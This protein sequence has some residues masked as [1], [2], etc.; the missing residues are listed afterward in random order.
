M[1]QRVS[2]DIFVFCVAKTTAK[3]TLRNYILV[4]CMGA[5]GFLVDGTVVK[6]PV[7]R[8]QIPEFYMRACA[9]VWLGEGRAT[10]SGIPSKRFLIFLFL[11][12][13][14]FF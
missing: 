13:F 8:H 1:I 3:S 6:M 2:V 7:C 14:L 10:I 11:F 5:R 9:C 4:S 12:L